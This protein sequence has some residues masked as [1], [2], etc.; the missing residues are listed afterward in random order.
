MWWVLDLY[1]TFQ[2]GDPDTYIVAG[3]AILPTL[4]VNHLVPKLG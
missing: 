2:V 4:G 3:P 1:R